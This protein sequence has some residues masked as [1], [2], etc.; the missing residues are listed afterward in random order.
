M[1]GRERGRIWREREGGRRGGY[2][3]RGRSGEGKG[4]EHVHGAIRDH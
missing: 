1:R 4:E 3:E 2:G